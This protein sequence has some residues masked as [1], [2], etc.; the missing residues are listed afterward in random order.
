M[1]MTNHM[2]RHGTVGDRRSILV[3][4]ILMHRPKTGGNK[5]APSPG[6]WVVS[7][8]QSL[9]MITNNL[10]CRICEQ[11]CVLLMWI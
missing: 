11:C 7:Q 5:T 10:D 2:I 4:D 6:S 1:V 8:S 3:L 9:S